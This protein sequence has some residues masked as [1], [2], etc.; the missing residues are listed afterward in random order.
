[1]LSEQNGFIFILDMKYFMLI[2][3]HFIDDLMNYLAYI[4]IY[5]WML[6]RKMPFE[7]ENI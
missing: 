5:S 7:K 1:M 3:S 2:P 6:E 4:Y